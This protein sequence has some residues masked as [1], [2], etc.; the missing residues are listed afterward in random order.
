MQFNCRE[1][2]IQMTPLWKGERLPDGRPHVPASVLDR[3]RR[4]TVEEVWNVGWVNNY[5]YQFERD[6]RSTHDATVPLIGR[7]VTATFAPIREDLELAMKRQ[8]KAQGMT[9]DYN[10]W[11]VDNLIEDDVIVADMFDKIKEG[12]LVGGN[13]STAI[14]NK[15]KRG[16]AVVWGGIRDL[17]QIQGIEGINIFY[18]GIDPTPLREY[19]MIGYNTPTRI[20]HAICLPGDIVYGCKSGVYFIPAHLAEEV[21]DDAERVH[22][23]DMFGFQRVRE[24]RYNAAIVDSFPWSMEMFEDFLEWFKTDE[25]AKPYQHLDWTKDLEETKAGVSRTHLR[26]IQ[27][28]V[29]KSVKDV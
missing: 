11:L 16:G 23:K 2:I 15:T 25:K 3:L 18:R 5:N 12:T 10:Q 26:Y 21:V 13:L 14:S 20:G 29:M 22:V 6:L 7:A 4:M 8:A 28:S 24:G 19:V 27:G 9:N 1:D 17:A